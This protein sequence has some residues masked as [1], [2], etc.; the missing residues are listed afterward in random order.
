MALR[1]ILRLLSLCVV[2]RRCPSSPS[3]TCSWGFFPP[4]KFS[5]FLAPS[6]S[7]SSRSARLIASRACTCRC[8][9]LRASV[10]WDVQLRLLD[11]QKSLTCVVSV[12]LA[13]CMLTTFAS[14]MLATTSAACVERESKVRPQQ[15]QKHRDVRRESC[16]WSHLLFPRRSTAM[17]ARSICC[18]VMSIFP[19]PS[20]PALCLARVASSLAPIFWHLTRRRRGRAPTRARH[21]HW[22]V[23]GLK[24]IAAH[25]RKRVN[26][27][28]SVC[29]G[30]ALKGGS[31]PPSN[32]LTIHK[33]QQ[34]RRTRTGQVTS[35]KEANRAFNYSL[36][37]LPS[38]LQPVAHTFFSFV[39]SHHIPTPLLS[40]S[41]RGERK[42]SLAVT[43][44]LLWQR[45]PS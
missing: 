13:S 4:P 16:R 21:R 27:P 45:Q 33:E 36:S 10:A 30:L 34:K 6:S 22:N 37:V 14:S 12:A 7:S 17:F 28:P 8:R 9:S 35:K 29:S 41:V 38:K 39:F 31:Q 26:P 44:R 18:A 11:S 5:L 3:G 43:Q 24:K 1:G 40:Q 19:Q 15:F 32:L 20:S 2:C 25:S 23:H 42:A